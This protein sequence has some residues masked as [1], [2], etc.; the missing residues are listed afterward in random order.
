MTPMLIK[1]VDDVGHVKC[2]TRVDSFRA[3]GHGFIPRK[4]IEKTLVGH[5][6]YNISRGTEPTT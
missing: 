2:V 6:I 1:D 4:T 3:L 5:I